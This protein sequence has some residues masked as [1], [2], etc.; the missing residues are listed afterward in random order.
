[1]GRES[2][3]LNAL[4]SAMA[5]WLEIAVGMV[6]Q[7]AGSGGATRVKMFISERN[8]HAPVTKE[9]GGRS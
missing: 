2:G 4:Q 3:V 8:W 5:A 9:A 7:P 6:H 1:L